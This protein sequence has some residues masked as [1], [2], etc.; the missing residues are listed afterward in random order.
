MASRCCK[1][2]ENLLGWL[3]L[4]VDKGGM[5]QFFSSSKQYVVFIECM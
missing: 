5:P 2:Q 3:K 4:T 1:G